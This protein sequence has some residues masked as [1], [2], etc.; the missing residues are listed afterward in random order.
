MGSC[1]QETC[2]CIRS[3]SLRDVESIYPRAFNSL[4]YNMGVKS[5]RI[6]SRAP[7]M[8]EASPEHGV[9]LRDA[10][11]KGP[12]EPRSH[13]HH[14]HWPCNLM[15]GRWF[16]WDDL[17]FFE[18]TEAVSG[19]LKERAPRH[20][21]SSKTQGPTCPENPEPLRMHAGCVFTTELP[22]ADVVESEKV[23][24][25]RYLCDIKESKKTLMWEHAKISVHFPGLT[26]VSLDTHDSF[27]NRLGSKAASSSLD[28]EAH[29]PF[30]TDDVQICLSLTKGIQI[31]FFP[32]H[33]H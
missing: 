24:S 33:E 13:I 20:P 27:G 7:Y 28:Q 1:L 16:S 19:G 8:T 11:G 15:L 18:L 17:R 12:T 21:P 25:W 5:F 9:F 30:S 4:S 14:K 26:S 29:F 10:E 2:L 3:L 23:I 22:K 32:G 6:P 31:E